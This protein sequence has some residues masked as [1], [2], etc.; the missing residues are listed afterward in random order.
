MG[1]VATSALTPAT[2]LRVRSGG[3]C[4]R[5]RAREQTLYETKDAVEIKALVA[6]VQ[7]DEDESGF[8]CMCCGNPSLEF[9]AGDRLLL[10]LGFHHGKGLRWVEGWRG[11]AALTAKSSSFLVRWLADRN[12]KGPLEEREEAA[13]RV[14]A[15]DRKTAQAISGMPP[16]L[17]KAFLAGNDEFKAALARE[18]PDKKEQ[19]MVCL[20]VFGTSNDSWTMLESLE[21]RADAL[22]G[23]YNIA[24]LAAA[25]EEALLGRDRQARRGAARLWMSYRSPLDDWKPSNIAELRRIVVQVE[26]EARY[27]PLRMDAVSHLATWKE[28]FAAEEIDRRL[29]AGL[30]DPAPQVRRKAMLIAGQIKHSA[31]IATLMSVLQGKAITTEPLPDVPQWEK[32]DVPKGFG[33]VAKGCS[34]VEVAGLALGYMNHAVAKSLLEHMQPRTAMVEV[35]L[36]LLGDGSQLKSEHFKSKDDNQELQLA[37]VEAVIRFKGRHGLQHAL[38]YRQATH[39]WEEEVVAERL[40]QMLREEKAPGSEKLQNCK[41]L[42]EL[43]KWFNAHG[44]EYL[45]TGATGT[46][47]R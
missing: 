30:H 39:W 34:D 8:H 25:A 2:R 3:T 27:Y 15:S 33:D 6:G 23:G 5:D 38:D 13:E 10:T 17:A 46:D 21:Q 32:T 40:S 12:V 41:N 24:V 42:E 36:V 47:R 43:Q 7:I 4:H 20:Q 14:R 22:L 1:E 35:S 19:A 29:R 37:A 28:S 31:S 44:A 16:A 18:L 45:S 9:Y 11:D 26:Q